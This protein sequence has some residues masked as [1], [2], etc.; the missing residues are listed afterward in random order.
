MGLLAAYGWSSSFAQ[1]LGADGCVPPRVMSEQRDR[2][3]AV[4]ASGELPVELSGRLRFECRS[5]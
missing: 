2:Y 4:C 5:T 3:W 1:H